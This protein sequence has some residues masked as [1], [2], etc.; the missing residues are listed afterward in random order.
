MI[1]GDINEERFLD[2]FVITK[3]V[4]VSSKLLVFGSKELFKVFNF[5]DLLDIGRGQR[6]RG[7]TKI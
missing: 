5:S 7:K 2:F 1:S 3:T 4:Q 6:R